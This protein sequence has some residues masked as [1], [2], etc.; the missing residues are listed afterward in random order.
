MTKKKQLLSLKIGEH[1]I[2]NSGF[3]L[4][5]HSI[6]KSGFIYSKSKSVRVLGGKCGL[7]ALLERQRWVA[8]TTKTNT[9]IILLSICQHFICMC[10]KIMNTWTYTCSKNIDLLQNKWECYSRKKADL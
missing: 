1:N 4:G 3:I 9:E 2:G 7:S 5:E 6:G 10:V 8:I